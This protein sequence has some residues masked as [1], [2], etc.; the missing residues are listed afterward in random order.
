[1]KLKTYFRILALCLVTILMSPGYAKDLKIISFNLEA[2]GSNINVLANQLEDLSAQREV[3]IWLFSDINPQWTDELANAIAIGSGIEIDFVP[4]NAGKNNRYLIVFNNQRF[5]VLDIGNPGLEYTFNQYLLTLVKFRERAS[6]K[7]FMTL[8][9]PSSSTDFISAF[10][11]EDLNLWAR[12]INEPVIA[13]GH[14]GFT[15]PVSPKDG[16]LDSRFMEM[17]KDDIFG[18]MRPIE[19]IPDYCARK[20]AI[21]NFVLIAEAANTWSG[22]AEVIPMT[23]SYCNDHRDNAHDSNHRPVYARIST[24]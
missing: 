4:G 14:F 21:F 23:S 2:Q 11:A 24:F 10:L 9:N 12:T 16:S 3:D 22:K 15:L 20:N 8:L 13:V 1:M 18:W 5:E 19:L 6:G 17:V 7:I